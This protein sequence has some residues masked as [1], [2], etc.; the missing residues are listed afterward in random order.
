VTEPCENCD[1]G[2]SDPDFEYDTVE[3]GLSLP[4][5]AVLDGHIRGR[6][7]VD[8]AD[9]EKVEICGDSVTITVR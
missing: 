7:D 8:P 6:T 5:A 2:L 9:V 3:F 4:L 1:C